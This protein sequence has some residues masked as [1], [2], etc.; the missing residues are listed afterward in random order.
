MAYVAESV[1][2]LLDAWDTELLYSVLCVAEAGL[3]ELPV[4]G[5]DNIHAGTIRPLTPL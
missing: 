2:N 1:Y 4:A 3:H 5:R